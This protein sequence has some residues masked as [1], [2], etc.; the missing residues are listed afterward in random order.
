MRTVPLAL[1]ELQAPVSHRSEKRDLGWADFGADFGDRHQIQMSFE[2]S[3][4]CPRVENLRN[5]KHFTRAYEMTMKAQLVRRFARTNF[6]QESS[7]T[8]LPFHPSPG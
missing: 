5:L 4:A 8:T 2:S 7:A 1:S 6:E 3:A